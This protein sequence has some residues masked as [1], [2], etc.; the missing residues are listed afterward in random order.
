M[1]QFKPFG[2]CVFDYET[3]GL[4]IYADSK[5]FLLGLEDEKGQVLLARPKTPEWALAHKILADPK[6]EKIGWNAKFDIGVSEA[7]GN[8]VRGLVHDAMLLTFMNHEYEPSLKLKEVAA[9]QLEIPADEETSVKKELARLNRE[10]RKE[11][12]GRE[13]NYSDLPDEL[14][15][16]YLEG[17][18]DRTM[19]LF[20]KHEHIIKGPQ[21]R[22]YQIEREL[23]PNVVSMEKR[24]VK[25]DVEYC[26]KISDHLVPRM[27]ELEKEMIN[28]AGVKFKFSSPMDITTVMESLGLDTGVKNANGTMNTNAT[29]MK[30]LQGKPFIDMLMEWRAMHKLEDTYFNSL[31]AKQVD[32]IV[33]PSFWPF[34]QNE[35]IKTGRFS[36]SDPNLQN[37]PA[38]QRKDNAAMKGD[39]GMVRRAFVPRPG[40]VF[41]L[42]DFSQ[43]EFRVFSCLVGDTR[44]LAE[45]KKGTDFHAA[46]AY[47]LFGKNCMDGK[48][49]EQIARIRFK[50][51]ELNFS[52]LYGMGLNKF[53]LRNNCSIQEARDAKNKYFNEIPSAKRFMM[54]SQ[55]S[56]L[57][58]G[59][60]Q[61]VFGRRYHVPV[62]R[63]YKAAN[64]LCQGAAALVLKRGINKTFRNLRGLDAHPIL[65]IHDEIIVECKIKD[66]QDAKVALEEGMTDTENFPIHMN[67]DISVAVPSWA[68]KIAWKDSK[69]A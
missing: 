4:R 9:R 1:K 2:R 14:V 3:D 55:V 59:Y 11:G 34:G 67:V 49:K 28:L 68:D 62:E 33:H 32:S 8:P 57:R 35:G 64:A 5:P 24:G 39:G 52:F 63:S 58:D 54:E 29:H 66:I 42:G 44:L 56:L 18:L 23:I 10:F 12:N 19:K 48:T 53:A 40:Y 13:A 37:I 26:R 27:R 65:T 17:D 69:Y 45:L 47:L 43:I 46:T 21:R 50:A 38:G 41:L 60:V 20:W 30:L 7:N 25:I 51:K 22:V 31:M 6:V 15:T 61:D 16:P 36:M